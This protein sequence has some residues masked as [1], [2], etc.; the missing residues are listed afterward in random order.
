[1]N[2]VKFQDVIIE[3]DDFFNEK[4]KGKYA[5]VINWLY[6][7]LLD[8]QEK[9][10]IQ[11][12][13]EQVEI[14]LEKHLKKLYD[15]RQYIDMEETEK[16]NSVDHYRYL[17]QFT[18]D[19]DITI[20]EIKQFRT[21]VALLLKEF[22]DFH[23]PEQ[24]QL[25]QMINFYANNGADDVINMLLNTMSMYYPS[26]DV[27]NIHN[28][29]GCGSNNN[30]ITTTNYNVNA[31]DPIAIY[32]TSIYNIM[33]K[34]F[35]DIEFWIGKEDIIKEIIK[36]LENIIKLNLPLTAAQEQQIACAV[37][38][39][40]LQEKYIDALKNLVT[41]FKYIL[42]DEITTNKNFISSAFNFWAKELYTNM[43]W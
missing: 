31:C 37:T 28:S 26:I 19:E 12:S 24:S 2:L 17:N 25:I 16:I 43:I 29:C 10:Y 1:M 4:L 42:D 21:K 27:K 9:E 14:N 39:I 13:K 5:Y 11:L 3:G 41:A 20:D 34:Y 30:I 38:S 40:N 33:V 22:Y 18:P 35:S 15:Y 36:Y 23:T 6:I 7:V 32:T 8:L